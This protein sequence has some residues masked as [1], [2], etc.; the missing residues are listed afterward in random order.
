M[1]VQVASHHHNAAEQ[2]SQAAFHHKQAQAHFEAGRQS[3]G[4]HHA[5]LAQAHQHYAN[6]WANEASKAYLDAQAH[7]TSTRAAA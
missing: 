5:M 3:E 6:V 7:G 4:L 1:S 2:L